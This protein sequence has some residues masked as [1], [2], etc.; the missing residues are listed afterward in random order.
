[1]QTKQKQKW[2]R[3]KENRYFIYNCL[4]FIFKYVYNVNKHGIFQK[5]SH[6]PLSLDLP[7]PPPNLV[8]IKYM[9]VLLKSLTW[10]S[11]Q[12]SLEWLIM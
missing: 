10:A 1:M 12:V 2:R 6:L 3:E 7:T 9:L 11:G 4:N 5:V 8:K